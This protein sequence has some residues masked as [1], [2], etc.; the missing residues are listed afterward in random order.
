M[1]HLLIL[2]VVNQGGMRFKLVYVVWLDL[3]VSL[4]VLYLMCCF[5]KTPLI[6]H[7]YKLCFYF[8]N[9]SS[10]ELLKSTI[11]KQHMYKIKYTTSILNKK[12]TSIY[13]VQHTHMMQKDI[14]TTD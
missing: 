7:Q 14:S 10:N 8:Y 9:T 12:Y 1:Y 5:G 6:S 13:A 4:F 11:T 3:T 2:N